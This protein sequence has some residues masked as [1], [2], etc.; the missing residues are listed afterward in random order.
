MERQ[1][2]TRT[3]RR[4]EFFARARLERKL[5]LGKKKPPQQM[6]NWWD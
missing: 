1:M 6:V 3:F 2:T 5:E 4:W